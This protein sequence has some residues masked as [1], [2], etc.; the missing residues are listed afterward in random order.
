VKINPKI[1]SQIKPGWGGTGILTILQP[2]KKQDLKKK[3]K[4][5]KTGVQQCILAGYELFGSQKQLC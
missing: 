1:H 3:K 4:K 2:N 5:K